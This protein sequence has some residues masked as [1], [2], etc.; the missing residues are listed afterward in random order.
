MRESFLILRIGYT[1]FSISYRLHHNRRWLAAKGRW[2]HK[3]WRRVN[4]SLAA[5]VGAIGFNVSCNK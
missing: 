4:A 1:Y 3:A 5:L 2:E